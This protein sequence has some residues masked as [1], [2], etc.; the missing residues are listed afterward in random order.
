MSRFRH[1]AIVASICCFAVAAFAADNPQP[2]AVGGE[3][4]PIQPGGAA[5]SGPVLTDPT[6]GVPD[7]PEN[8][9][10]IEEL[11][12]GEMFLEA[13]PVPVPA[14]TIDAAREAR[15]AAFDAVMA[16]QDAK[17][18]TL[19]DRLTAMPNGPAGLEIQ[20]EIEHE[21]LATSRLLLELQLDFAVRAGNEEQISV[22][23]AA[24]EAWDA[25]PPAPQPIDRPAPANNGR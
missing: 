11:R 10:E 6:A 12:R 22:L 21:K 23:R 8:Q 15:R 9:A 1:I 2:A 24:L 5:G 13:V 18:Q 3:S 17:I 20:Q 16:S 19:T 4:A 7:I 25:P 14:S